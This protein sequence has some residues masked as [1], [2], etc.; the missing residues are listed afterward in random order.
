MAWMWTDD[1]AARLA[2]EGLRDEKDVDAWR[3]HPV[4]IAV[5]DELD[6]AAFDDPSP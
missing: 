4:A 3:L 5:P 2:A 1:L 6:P